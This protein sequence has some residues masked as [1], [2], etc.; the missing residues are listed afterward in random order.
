MLHARF[1]PNLQ[2]YSE[3]PNTA[4]K[5]SLAKFIERAVKTLNDQEKDARYMLVI[6][7]EL[8]ESYRVHLKIIRLKGI[9]WDGQKLPL[10]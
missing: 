3:D 5:N 9:K 4:D 1:I 7:G 2:T 6:G 10:T 8:R